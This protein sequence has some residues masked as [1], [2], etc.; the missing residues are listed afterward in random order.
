MVALNADKAVEMET[1]AF[2]NT[3]AREADFEAKCK[4]VS[5]HA[6]AAVHIGFDSQVANANSFLMP[7]NSTLEIQNI[8]FTRVSAQGDAGTGNLYILARR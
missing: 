5:L 4:S 6:S 7:A 3:Q 8:E 1:I 2:T